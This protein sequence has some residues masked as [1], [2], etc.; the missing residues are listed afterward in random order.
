MPN[1]ADE[2]SGHAF[3]SYVKE[4]RDR[5]ASIVS[6]LKAADIPVWTDKGKLSPGEDWK[7][8]IRKAIQRNALAFIAVFSDNSASRDASYQNEE[9][10]LAIDQFKLHP[11]G[12]VWLIPVR[13]D[14]CEL[15]DYELGAGRTLDSLQRVDLFGGDEQDERIRLVTAVLKILGESTSDSATIR[16]S[17]SQADAGSRGPSL[18]R[19]I[20]AMVLE[21][22]RQIELED[23]LVD[24]AARTKADLDGTECTSDLLSELN[25]TP[26]GVRAVVN[27]FREYESLVEPLGYGLAMLC[28]RAQDS[29]SAI[30]TRTVRT[31]ASRLDGPQTGNTFLIGLRRYPVHVAVHAAALGALSRSNYGALRA[32]VVEPIVRDSGQRQ[33]LLSHMHPGEYIYP[34]PAAANFLAIDTP[35]APVSDEQIEGWRRGGRRYTPISDHLHDLLRPQLASLIPDDSDFSDLFDEAEVLLAVLAAD[36]K[37]QAKQRGQYRHGAWYGRFSWRE[38]HVDNPLYQRMHIDLLAAG[39]AWK[40]LQAGLFG[41]SQERAI[42]AFED[43]GPEAHRA[44]S[45]R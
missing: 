22:Q 35:D 1:A 26:A 29:Q 44:M 15:P 23:L 5:I 38:R 31:L 30:I 25:D 32:A 14:D 11:P 16:A 20:K 21:P 4:D 37:L 33:S 42:A 17:I 3:V 13:L 34:L 36:E 40:P 10:L 12:R 19:G 8:V 45:F 7:L 39:D 18:A 9:L 43:F 6:S 24:E 41:G 27:R 28:A 2:T